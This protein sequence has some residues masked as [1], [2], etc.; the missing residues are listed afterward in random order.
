[1]EKSL[2]IL[3]D[4]IRDAEKWSG[5]HQPFAYRELIITNLKKVIDISQHNNTIFVQKL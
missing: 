2:Q 5:Q 3:V 4:R 1:M